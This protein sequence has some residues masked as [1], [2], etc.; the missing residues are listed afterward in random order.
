ML[1]INV[2][3]KLCNDLGVGLGLEFVAFGLEQSLQFLVVGND[4]IVDNG[5]FPFGVGSVIAVVSR[6]FTALLCESHK[7][8]RNIPVR[9]AVETGRFAVSGP[10]SVCNTGVGIKDLLHV[11]IALFNELTEFGNL[12]DLLESKHFI[13]LV[14]IDGQTS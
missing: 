5:E 10:A 8:L 7:T 2:L 3:G 4:T 6:R 12:A 14:T 11:Y 1:R 9:M 13:L